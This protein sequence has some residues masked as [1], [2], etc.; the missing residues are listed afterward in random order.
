MKILTGFATFLLVAFALQG[1]PPT[2]PVNSDYEELP[3]LKASEILRDTILN[4]PNHK[5]REEVPTE[6]GANRFTIESH[7]GIF[8][9]EGNAMLVRRVDEINA[10]GRLKEVSKT[11]AFKEALKKAAMSPLNTAKALVT[12]P[13]KTVSAIPKGL[14]KFIGRAGETVKSVGKKK[15][16]EDGDGTR[17]NVQNIVGFTDAK[18]KVAVSLGVDPYSTNQVLQKQLDDITWAN[19][20]GGMVFSLGTMG[21]GGG[22]GTALTATQVTGTFEQVLKEKNPTDLKLMNRKI[23]LGLGASS[24]DT[25]RFLK[26][27]AFSPSAQTAFA[28]NLQALDGVANRGAFVRLAGTISASE[29]DAIFCV[30]TA[31]L[32]GNLHKGETPLARIELLGDFPICIAKD[33]TTVVALQWDYAAYTPLADQFSRDLEQFTKDKGHNRLIALSGVASPRL[34]QELEAR[35]DTVK[36]KLAPGPLK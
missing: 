18:R 22:V 5:V 4:G 19:F 23:L 20:A 3:E 25:E 13:V 14:K 7:F 16:S 15:D 6:S 26:N 24:A 8:T 12:D 32:M 33:G 21:I 34:R 11:D 35:G 28:L 10:I 9:A 29:P 27:T 31:A 1:Q 17:N 36:D 30:Q 2:L